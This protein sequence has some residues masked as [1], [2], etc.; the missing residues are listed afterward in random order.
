MKLILIISLL[1]Q[2]ILF[3]QK[4]NFNISSELFGPSVFYSV[5]VGLDYRLKDSSSIGLKLM[6]SYWPETNW[7]NGSIIPI[8]IQFHYSNKNWLK[9]KSYFRA[10]VTNYYTKIINSSETIYDTHNA[11]N[12]GFGYN[13]FKKKSPHKLFIGT[14]VLLNLHT[15][16]KPEKGV[17][18]FIPLPTIQYKYIL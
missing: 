14:D 9:G 13:I 17:F 11:F 16:G 4:Y 3:G 8:S 6:S 18:P 10:G 5:G 2:T 1:S 7:N 15:F 12:V